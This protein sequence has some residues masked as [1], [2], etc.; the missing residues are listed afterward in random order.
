VKSAGESSLASDVT[1]QKTASFSNLFLRER[2][3]SALRRASREG[4]LPIGIT[5][6][7][8]LQREH[9]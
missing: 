9:W 5:E 8:Y 2:G 4:G 7:F 6:V 3:A 1:V